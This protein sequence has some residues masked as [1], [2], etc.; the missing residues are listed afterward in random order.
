M[1]KF[2]IEVE[3]TR[4]YRCVYE[5]DAPSETEAIDSLYG[6][7]EPSSEE[8]IETSKS[9]IVS[10]QQIDSIEELLNQVKRMTAHEDE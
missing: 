9:D 6:S 7:G 2:R 8:F 5:L 4:T 1:S 3:E 10:V